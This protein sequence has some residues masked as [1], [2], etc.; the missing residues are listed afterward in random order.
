[1]TLN[2][3]TLSIIMNTVTLSIMQIIVTLSVIF[4]VSLMPSVTYG[5][6]MLS[7]I[8]LNVVAPK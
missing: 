8:M 5:L 2:L 4:A 6:F 1:M 3:T 7:V